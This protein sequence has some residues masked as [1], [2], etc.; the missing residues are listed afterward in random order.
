MKRKVSA[1]LRT[2]RVHNSSGIPTLYLYYIP[3]ADTVQSIMS[4]LPHSQSI[5]AYNPPRLLPCFDYFTF[6]TSR[7]A[8][9][10]SEIR[11]SDNSSYD[12]TLSGA[13]AKS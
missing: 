1:R 7:T 8:L 5:P 10:Y 13:L 12:F 2:S 6:L 11:N 3:A 9:S 4:L